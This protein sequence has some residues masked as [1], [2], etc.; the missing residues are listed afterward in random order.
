[1]LNHD[2]KETYR[3]DID[4]KQGNNIQKLQFQQLM[5]ENED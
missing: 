2:D 1:V 3:F 5:Y 4:I